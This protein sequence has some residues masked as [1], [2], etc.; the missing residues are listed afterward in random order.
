MATTQTTGRKMGFPSV[1]AAIFT[2][3]ELTNRP[4]DSG[5][6]NCTSSI[7]ASGIS[8]LT[9]HTTGHTSLDLAERLYGDDGGTPE[10]VK[11][12]DDDDD[13]EDD[14]SAGV[15]EVP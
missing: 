14:G 6:V 9:S 15:T 1:R 3:T 10:A 12:L 11:Y 8:T 4:T 5:T 13:D 2:F 7:E